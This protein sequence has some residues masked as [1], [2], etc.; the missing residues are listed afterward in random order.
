MEFRRACLRP[1][2]LPALVLLGLAALAAGFP[3]TL[4][5]DAP[6]LRTVDLGAAGDAG[7]R[8][9]AR[10]VAQLLRQVT[11]DARITVRGEDRLLLPVPAGLA[12]LDD[13][14]PLGER[15]DGLLARPWRRAPPATP[16]T[17]G[18]F[19]A[20][21]GPAQRPQRC[22]TLA[23]SGA[24]PL[25]RTIC[26]DRDGEVSL[27]ATL[28]PDG[29]VREWEVVARGAAADGDVRFLVFDAF[30]VR[31]DLADFGPP[32]R[33]TL[34]PA[35]QICAGCHY[36]PAQDRFRR[37]PAHAA[38]LDRRFAA[39]YPEARMALASRP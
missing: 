14:R 26:R 23:R 1:L 28:L 15:L 8:G 13:R 36:D 11:G 5:A 7:V 31:T 4:R 29:S 19:L 16:E 38:E 9:R 20:S 37:S 2:A 39:V 24:K 32:G 25:P 6:D 10:L 12:L 35:P 3:H 33:E 21:L 34:L 22:L 27:A 30:G 18:A 17:L